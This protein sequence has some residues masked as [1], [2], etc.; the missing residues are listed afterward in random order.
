MLNSAFHKLMSHRKWILI[1]LLIFSVI[2]RIILTLYRQINADEF[3]H[4]HASWLIHLG[5][6]PYRDFWENH[7][8]L[9]YYLTAPVLS[10]LE[11]GVSAVLVIRMFH[12]LAGL[13]IA[14]LIYRIA[15]L[16]NDRTTA[17]LAVLVLCFSEIFL[18]KTI[19]VRTDQFLVLFWLLSLWFCFRTGVSTR[20]GGLWISGLMLGIGMLFSPKALI[21][22]AA[23]AITV[24]TQA[25]YGLHRILK[26]QIF[27]LGGFLIPIA[28]L[29]VFFHTKGIFHVW[30]DSTIFQNL[31]YPDTRGPA[32]LL[33][34]QNLGFILL[35]FAGMI[36]SLRGR[37]SR[38][39]TLSSFL[40]VPAL[41]PFVVLVF[42]LPSAFSQS[43]L[44]FIP[45][46]AIYAGFALNKSLRRI[47]G[48]DFKRILFLAFT[49]FTGLVL[50]IAALL[51]RISS[52]DT[53]Q[54]Q[55]DL[56]R[57]IIMN[58]NR[59]EPIF[60]GNAAYVFRKQAYY[61][62]SLVEGLR[63]KIK[64]GEI[65]ESIPESLKQNHCR[66]VLYDDRVSDLPQKIQ[67]FLR[68]NYLPAE[69][70]SV[71]VAGKILGAENLTGNKAVFR[72]EIPLLY[73]IEARGGEKLK[74][75]GRLYDK[76]VWLNPGLHELV[77]VQPLRSVTVRADLKEPE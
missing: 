5:S 9:L 11:E 57:Y 37:K 24:F 55:M 59:D 75:D 72:I 21:C 70:E 67:D 36:L 42:F 7:S 13:A 76:P 58:T 25:R 56:I 17:I 28:A 61:Y 68:T 40:L 38:T 62:G 44:T 65:S 34:P 1:L 23:A 73:R 10:L 35:G 77:S 54:K 20:D 69:Y 31:S 60:D 74:I 32:F 30:I 3:Q 26:R 52:T 46:F 22:A 12:S 39:H 71:Y 63:Y 41:L 15:G 53:N 51:L 8:P 14:G 43:A 33:L 19:E 66:I 49:V 16:D 18:Q 6:L 2:A 4:L 64:R 27:F 48:L 47:Q 45:I 50:P 29:G